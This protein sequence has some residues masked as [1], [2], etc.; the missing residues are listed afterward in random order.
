MAEKSAPPT[1]QELAAMPENEFLELSRDC[2]RVDSEYAFKEAGIDALNAA[3][4]GALATMF[5]LS[6]APYAVL[7]TVISATLAGVSVW[8]GIQAVGEG[9]RKASQSSS[10]DTILK[11]LY[12]PEPPASDSPSAVIHEA[13]PNGRVMSPIASGV[14]R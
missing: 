12:A 2:D 14:T 8:R 5:A 6:G 10:A 9:V 7:G 4:Q 11:V 3:G 1:V 13:E